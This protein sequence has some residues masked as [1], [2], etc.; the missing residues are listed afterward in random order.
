MCKNKHG[1]TIAIY[2]LSYLIFTLMKMF[3]FFISPAALLTTLM[4]HVSKS[5]KQGVKN[6]LLHSRGV[7][8]TIIYVMSA[9]QTLS[10][11]TSSQVPNS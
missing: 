7:I 1:K 11:R 2:R 9:L 8:K 3:L 10:T 5:S 6:V 4:L